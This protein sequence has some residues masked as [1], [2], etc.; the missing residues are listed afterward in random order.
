MS[1]QKIR[2]LLNSYDSSPTECDGMTRI[3]HTVLCNNDIP[4]NVQFG[5]CQYQTQLIPVHF[6]IELGNELGGWYVDY[7]LRMWLEGKNKHI[8]HGVFQLAKFPEIKYQGVTIA[9]EPMPKIIFQALLSE[10]RCLINPM[11]L[12]GI[13][14]AIAMCQVLSK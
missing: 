8:P 12:S 1:A 10:P 7:R 4:H 11:P 5:I 2:E 6:W 13:E 14:K 9:I 3:C